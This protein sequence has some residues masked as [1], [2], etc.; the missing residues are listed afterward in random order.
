[1]V[2]GEARWGIITAVGQLRYLH[3]L[4]QVCWVLSV[5]TQHSPP[6]TFWVSRIIFS[7]SA[8]WKDR[9]YRRKTDTATSRCLSQIWWPTKTQWRRTKQ[10]HSQPVRGTTQSITRCI[11]MCKLFC[12]LSPC[13]G[14]HSPH[15]PLT[16]HWLHC[17]LWMSGQTAIFSVTS[18]P[19]WDSAHTRYQPS[20]WRYTT[21]TA[22]GIVSFLPSLSPQLG[23]TPAGA[24]LLIIKVFIILFNDSPVM[25]L[26]GNH[27]WTSHYFEICLSKYLVSF[28]IWCWTI[29]INHN[30]SSYRLSNFQHFSHQSLDIISTR[31]KILPCLQS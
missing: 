7:P 3:F 1:M 30:K 22:L 24:E 23:L 18:R 12:Q 27:S 2:W 26:Q 9:G 29:E 10:L 8:D 6:S 11:L 16:L 5:N 13:V 14:Q 21:L 19:M 17:R 25:I 15:I 28:C 31:F 20:D 4:S